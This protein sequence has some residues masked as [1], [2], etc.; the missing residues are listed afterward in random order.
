ML[1]E[2]LDIKSMIY[3]IRGKQVM[4]D[5]DLAKLYQCKNGTKEVN[6]AVKNNMEK[7]PLRYAFRIDEK[8]YSYLKSN[9]LTSKGGSRKGHTV[10][11]E[12]GVAM[13]S[14]ILKSKIAVKVSISI[15][16]AFVEMRKYINTNMLEQK[17]VNNLVMNHEERIVVLEEIF[18]EFKEENHYIFFKG[19]KYDAYSLMISIFNKSKKSII[20]I[21]NYVDKV[22]LDILSKTKKKVIVIT[23]KYNNEDY[24]KYKSQYNNI[25]LIINNDFHDRFII[26]DKK[27]LYHCGSSFK[28]LGKSCFEISLIDNENILKSLMKELVFTA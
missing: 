22:L 28:D 15:M 24:L 16:D 9:N 5:S 18:D 11:T 6:Q 27:I 10:F 25:D 17:Y 20:I 4:L 8:E 12:Q 14:T 3:E 26:V 1:E 2:K 7:F 21:D 19:Q 23:N 13:L